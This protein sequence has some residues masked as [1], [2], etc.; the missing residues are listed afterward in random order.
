MALP[1]KIKNLELL[2]DPAIPL[3]SIYHKELKEESQRD[4]CILGFIGTLFII[5]KKWK[6]PK[7]PS[8]NE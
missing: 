3:L 2:Y 8:M 7:C 4:I 5:V 1:Q 6:Q